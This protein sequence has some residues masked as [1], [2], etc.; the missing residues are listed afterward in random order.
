MVLKY[1]EFKTH[2]EHG[3]V[4]LEDT[5]LDVNEGIDTVFRMQEDGKLMEFS[6]SEL[7]V[8]KVNPHQ[9]PQ[10]PALS[11]FTYCRGEDE[12]KARDI[13]LEYLVTVFQDMYVRFRIIEGSMKVMQDKFTMEQK[14]Q[15]PS[16][17]IVN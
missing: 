1:L 4:W 13:L 2:P 9:D 14:Q 3:A 16:A 15:N 8:P 11:V 5:W 7:L 10:R 12:K 6:K 17:D